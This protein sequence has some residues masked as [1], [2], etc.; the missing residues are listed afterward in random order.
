MEMGKAS[1]TIFLCRY[2]SHEDL[3]IEINDALNV[4][5]RVNGIMEFIFYGRL[6]EISSNSTNEQEMSLLCL[7]LLQVCMVHINTLLIQEVL[8]DPKWKNILNKHDMRA[9]SPLLHGHINPYGFLH[10]D[11]EKRL[12]I[13]FNNQQYGEEV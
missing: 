5:E 9:L 11:M 13:K 10:L 4:V 3:R 1:R 12:N 2:L 8:L 6:G 7:H